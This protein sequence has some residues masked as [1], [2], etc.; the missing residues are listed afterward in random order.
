MY[1]IWKIW[2][3]IFDLCNFFGY[4]KDLEGSPIMILELGFIQ[5]R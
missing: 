2:E 1:F 4:K 3:E 5:I